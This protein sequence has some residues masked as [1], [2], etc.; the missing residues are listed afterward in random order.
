[1]SVEIKN[2]KTL[3]ECMN[4][5]VEPEIICDFF[6]DFCDK[7]ETIQ[8]YHK[9]KS[10]PPFLFLHLQRLVFDLEFMY[11]IKLDHPI[12]FPHQLDLSQY[13]NVES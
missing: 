2:L 10:L 3:Q 12:N 11:K 6:C 1:M 7:K 5:Y 13:F 8:K 9:F 4:K